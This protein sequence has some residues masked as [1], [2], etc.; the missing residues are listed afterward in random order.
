MSTLGIIK[1]LSL[2]IVTLAIIVLLIWLFNPSTAKQLEKH[3]NIPL[4]D[5]KDSDLDE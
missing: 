4:N 2:L 5:T 1:L 3:K